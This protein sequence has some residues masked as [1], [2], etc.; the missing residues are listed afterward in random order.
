M[1]IACIV[2]AIIGI[3]TSSC[4]AQEDWSQNLWELEEGFRQN[5]KIAPIYGGGRYRILDDAFYVPTEEGRL[6]YDGLRPLFG[7]EKKG[8]R[9][10]RSRKKI[11]PYFGIEESFDDNIYQEYSNRESDFITT[12]P[13]GVAF[14]PVRFF[15]SPVEGRGLSSY[16][17]V[18]FINYLIHKE[19]NS[20]PVFP[21]VSFREQG[22]FSG[23]L[24]ADFSLSKEQEDSRNINSSVPSAIWNYWN[25]SYGARLHPNKIKK[26]FWNL[27][28]RHNGTI[29]GEGENGNNCKTDVFS[30]AGDLRMSPKTTISFGIDHEISTYPNDEQQNQTSDIP[31][32]GIA[33]NISRRLG[34]SAIFGYAVRHQSNTN[35][36]FT[37]PVINIGLQGKASRRF[38][39]RLHG[40]QDSGQATDITQGNLT[41]TGVSTGGTYSISKRQTISGYASYYVDDYESGR[42][43]H[44]MNL[45]LST[46]YQIKRLVSLVLEYRFTKQIST[47]VKSDG[48]YNN[49]VSLKVRKEFQ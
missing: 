41:E 5:R 33:Q 21:D 28:Y 32:I 16:L 30:A 1:R 10:G 44:V 3:L 49:V 42:K 39:W 15:T 35:K 8:R 43:D 22:L 26:F 46:Q 20:N 34:A 14:G 38:S 45:G 6:D 31:W 19:E 13:I 17:G 24:D 11:R 9:I 4:H 29:Y 27:G 23:M 12:I 48:Y 25:V 18:R 36:V 40:W 7:D 2:I 37:G 47:P